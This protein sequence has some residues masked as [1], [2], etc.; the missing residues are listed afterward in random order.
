MLTTNYAALS[1]YDYRPT[2]GT[3][4]AYGPHATNT[5]GL[6]HI[7]TDALLE[8]R[9]ACGMGVAYGRLLTVASLVATL[10]ANTRS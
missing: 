6:T 9:R 4:G 7:K 10:A 8:Y 5:R 2:I 3:G 1:N